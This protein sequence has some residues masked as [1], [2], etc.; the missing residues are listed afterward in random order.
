[1]SA[2]LLLGCPPKRAYCISEAVTVK[3]ARQAQTMLCKSQGAQTAGK[4]LGRMQ[5]M[6]NIQSL[7]GAG[8]VANKHWLATRSLSVHSLCLRDTRMWEDTAILF[9]APNGQTQSFPVLTRH[10]FV[11]HTQ[12]MHTSTQAYTHTHTREGAHTHTGT[13]TRTRMRAYTHTPIRLRTRTCTLDS[14]LRVQIHNLHRVLLRATI[15]YP[16][17]YGTAFRRECHCMR[18]ACRGQPFASKQSRCHVVAAVYSEMRQRSATASS[19]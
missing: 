15:S 16:L 4:F 5:R 8:V 18:G 7:G 17:K 19:P 1:M 2:G 11:K 9:S 10:L 13:S 12:H 14:A 6:T 3:D